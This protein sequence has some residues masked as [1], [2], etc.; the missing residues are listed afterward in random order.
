MGSARYLANCF[1]LAG[2]ISVLIFRRSVVFDP[3]GN[4]GETLLR[5]RR[6]DGN[7][8]KKSTVT[9]ANKHQDWLYTACR[10]RKEQVMF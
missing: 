9:I 1:E 8:M 5:L 2:N 6:F 3:D 10:G 7:E 4:R